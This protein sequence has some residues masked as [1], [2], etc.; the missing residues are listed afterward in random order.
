[1]IFAHIFSTHGRQFGSGVLLLL[2]VL[3]CAVIIATWPSKP[4]AK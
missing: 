4:A 1:M 2:I 3:A